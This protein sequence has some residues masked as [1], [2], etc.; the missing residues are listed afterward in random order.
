MARHPERPKSSRSSVFPVKFKGLVKDLRSF[1]RDLKPERRSEDSGLTTEKSGSIATE[2]PPSLSE[3]PAPLYTANLNVQ[4]ALQFDEP[5]DFMY[6][7]NYEG[8]PSLVV[9]EELCQT[10]LYRIDHCS[11]ELITRKDSSALQRTRYNGLGKA[12][13][14]ELHIQINLGAEVWASRTFVSYQKQPVTVETAREVT[15]ETHYMIGLFLRQHDD[16]FALKDG[17]IRDDPSQSPESYPFRAG[18]VQPMTCVPRSYFL[19]S[20]QNFE[21][22]PGYTIQLSL[23]NRN[24]RRKPSEW[25]NTIEVNSQQT[26]P[27][28]LAVA[29]S[30]FF[31]AAQAM[32]TVMRVERNSFEERHRSCTQPDGCS[33]WRQH[34][35]DGF[36]ME[37]SIKNNLGPQFEHLQRKVTSSIALLSHLQTGDCDKFVNDLERAFTTVRDGADEKINGM[38]DLEFRIIELRGRGWTLEEPLLFTIDTASTYSR[39]STEAVLDRV[40]A[41]I[42]DILR[43]NAMAVRMTAYKRGHLVLDKTLVA[44]EPLDPPEEKKKL[45]KTSK[46]QVLDRLRARIEKDI[47]LV[48]RDTCSLRSPEQGAQ[49]PNGTG[50]RCLPTYENESVTTVAQT[51]ITPSRA[52]VES[53]RDPNSIRTLTPS[54]AARSLRNEEPYPPQPSNPP[55]PV[56][57]LPSIHPGES[58]VRIPLINTPTKESS[59]VNKGRSNEGME[60]EGQRES[61]SKLSTNHSISGYL[62]RGRT[63]FPRLGPGTDVASTAPT[64]PSLVSGEIST[65][66]SSHEVPHNHNERALSIGTGSY[67]GSIADSDTHD[68]RGE[69]KN[70]VLRSNFF[71]GKTTLPSLKRWVTRPNKTPSPLH[72]AFTAS[73]GAAALEIARASEKRLQEKSPESKGDITA[74]TPSTPGVNVVP[75]LYNT[76]NRTTTTTNQASEASTT[77]PQP[78]PEPGTTTATTTEEP[79]DSLDEYEAALRSLETDTFSQ[80]RLEFDFSSPGST[81]TAGVPGSPTIGEVGDVSEI[82]PPATPPPPQPRK[83]LFSQ[84]MAQ[85]RNSFGGSAGFLG[86]HEEKMVQVSLRR[87]LM[88][89]PT[90]QKARSPNTN[91][92]KEEAH[93]PLTA[94]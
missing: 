41:G 27:L 14:F 12:V 35:G 18:R 38:K 78:K 67:G 20:S 1:T 77:G 83:K 91:K 55:P 87:A 93:K 45:Q 29:E 46:E 52:S 48:C 81:T 57:Y 51:T 4:V 53:T 88:G 49:I 24:H 8:S 75:E 34:E 82:E 92:G 94:R 60:D 90:P 72:H 47:E 58:G 64:T 2:P 32:E 15:L 19:Q 31:D 23:T 66:R 80:S 65:P 63:M 28:N 11:Q 61:S 74:R 10:L 5:L 26:T 25:R 50:P 39:R 71:S 40:Q 62:S 30:L 36:E 3:F 17:P 7:R 42:A 70:R 68:N 22:I 16:G 33:Y 13:R 37:L 73:E 79:G 6:S 76:T 56:P 43:R 21:S 84:T 86:F 85:N 9:T 54:H 59:E 69:D 89:S 44:R